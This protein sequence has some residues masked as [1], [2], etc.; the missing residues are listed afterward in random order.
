MKRVAAIAAV[1]VAGFA[2]A[3]VASAQIKT[4]IDVR[5]NDSSDASDAVLLGVLDSPKAK[6]ESGRTMKLL[7]RH[8]PGKGGGFELADIDRTSH[9]GAWAFRANLLGVSSARIRVAEKKLGHG[10]GTWAATQRRIRFA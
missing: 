3:G 2:I 9:A 10:N 1:L 4:T 5:D 6:C 7:V 8:V